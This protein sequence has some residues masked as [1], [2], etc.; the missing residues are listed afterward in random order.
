[1]ARAFAEI[2][3]VN[4][5]LFDGAAGQQLYAFRVPPLSDES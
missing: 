3:G 1:L 2:H 4:A 5:W